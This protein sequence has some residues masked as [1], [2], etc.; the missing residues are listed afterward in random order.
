MAALEITGITELNEMFSKATDV[1]DDVKKEILIAMGTVGMQSIR[2]EGRAMD[3]YD[4][5]WDGVHVLDSISLSKPKLSDFDGKIYVTFKGSRKRGNS[6]TRNAAIAFINEY[7]RNA[8]KNRKGIPMK[9]FVR[10]A[11]EKC[12]DAAIK[13]GEKVW[14]DWLDKL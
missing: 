3:V 5:D 14:H 10:I 4:P 1:P 8:S 9:P 11:V 6:K 2:D 13:A 12:T 7:G